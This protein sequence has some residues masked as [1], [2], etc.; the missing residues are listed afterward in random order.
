MEKRKQFEIALASAQMTATF[1][2][3]KVLGITLTGLSRILLGQSKSAR[4]TQEID[5]FISKEFARLGVYL[6]R[7]PEENR[8]A[9]ESARK[10]TRKVLKENSRYLRQKQ[11]LS[12]AS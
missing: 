9:V 2:A 11:R 3:E 8:R 1:F 5:G 7:I 6:G 12:R 10:A 4:I